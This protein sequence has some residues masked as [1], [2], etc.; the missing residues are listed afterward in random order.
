MIRSKALNNAR[1]EAL[2]KAGIEVRSSDA[3][4]VSETKN[5]LIDFYSKFAETS[6]KGII[7]DERIIRESE[8]KKVKG[9]SYEIEIEIEVIVALQIGEPDRGFEVNIESSEEAVKEG[10][11]FTLTVVTTK[12]G[13]LTIF[14]VYRDSLSVVFPNSIDKANRIIANKSF[15]FPPS[16]AY[17]LQLSVPQGK[18]T[19]EE[20]FIAVVTKERIPFPNFEETKLTDGAVMLK[21]GQ[22]KTYTNWLH[23]IP[24]QA[25]CSDQILM[26]ARK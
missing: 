7:L 11:S 16:K 21:M 13:Y 2:A 5:E 15:V 14:N 8:P 20:M 22:F 12:D 3:R 24:L 26:T 6:T 19:S 25:R 17:D 4:L 1:A 9:F 18:Q 10:E 23:T